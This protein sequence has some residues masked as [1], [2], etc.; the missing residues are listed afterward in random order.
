MNL[1]GNSDNLYRMMKATLFELNY[2][3]WGKRH[4]TLFKDVKLARSHEASI[5]AKDEALGGVV[6]GIVATGSE[7]IGSCQLR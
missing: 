1:T 4:C 6:E 3:H 7:S 5:R 2:Q